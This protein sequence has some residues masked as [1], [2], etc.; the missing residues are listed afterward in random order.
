[1]MAASLHIDIGCDT[2]YMCVILR[3]YVMRM[4]LIRMYVI[5][6]YVMRRLCVCI[7]MYVCM[8]VT[9]ICIIYVCTSYEYLIY[10][11]SQIRVK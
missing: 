4:Y 11:M 2:T 5:R 3:I 1:M 6:M 9:C 8:Y 7:C 10:E